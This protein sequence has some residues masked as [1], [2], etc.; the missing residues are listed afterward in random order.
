MEARTHSDGTRM[1]TLS[2][3][4][5]PH[6]PERNKV[7][8]HRVAWQATFT[9]TA[10][11]VKAAPGAA[12]SMVAKLVLAAH[13]AAVAL[14]ALPGVAVLLMAQPLCGQRRCRVL[15]RPQAG[16]YIHEVRPIGAVVRVRVAVHQLWVRM[17]HFWHCESQPHGAVL[18]QLHAS[19]HVA[20]SD[21]R[22]SVSGPMFRHGLQRRFCALC[23]SKQRTVSGCA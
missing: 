3:A 13:L 11:Q 5:V 20:C 2:A 1:R 9:C 17:A 4:A 14:R 19:K 22:P 12:M 10:M 23:E 7:A 16:P 8:A 15:P 18:A 21:A 6:L